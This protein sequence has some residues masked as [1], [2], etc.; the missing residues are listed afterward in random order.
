MRE[1]RKTDIPVHAGFDLAARAIYVDVKPY[2]KPGYKT[3]VTGHSLGGAVAAILTIY[4]IEDGVEVV[5]L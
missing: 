2:L 5:V 4:M 3:Y 1:D